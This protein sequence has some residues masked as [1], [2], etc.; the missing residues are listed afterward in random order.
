MAKGPEY[1][2]LGTFH[3]QVQCLTNE[4]VQLQDRNEKLYSKVEELQ[5]KL[6][7]LALSKADMSSRLICSEEEK[8]K[9]SK[10]FVDFQIDTNKKREQHEAENFELKNLILGL[11]NRILEIELHD[12]RTTGERDALQERLQTLEND[13][14][15]LANEYLALKSNYLVLGKEHEQELSKSE[16]LSRE[17]LNLVKSKQEHPHHVQTKSLESQTEAEEPSAEVERVQ[18]LIHRFS[19]RRAKPK[20]VVAAS[21]HED[22]KLE[23]SVS[24]NGAVISFPQIMEI[25]SAFHPSELLRN[26]G[27]ITEEMEKMR[28]MYSSQQQKL[29]ERMITMGKELQE[30][31]KAIRN[32]Q[33]KLA[34]E[35]A[36]LLSSHGQLQEVESENS[37]LQLQLKE[38]NEQYRS[39]LVQYITDLAEYTDSKSSAATK[40]P[41]Q[42][43]RFVDSM[44]KDIRASYKSR[45]EQL[46]RA[47]R[48]YKK[49]MQNLVKKHEGLLVAYRMQREQIRS[50][51]SP[52][53]DPGPPEHHFSITDAELLTNT[54]Q[55]LNRLREDKAS[56]EGQLYELQMKVKLSEKMIS[57]T[58]FHLLEGDGWAELRKQL[59]EFTHATQVELE[60]ERSQLLARAMVAEEQVAELQEY[61]DKHLVRY[62]QEIV[63]MHKLLGTDGS[64]ELSAGASAI[65]VLLMSQRNLNKEV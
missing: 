51:G 41:A 1:S 4:N 7:Q 39:H 10:D 38:L 29:E 35:S 58:S 15:E 26:Q 24:F 42:M 2:S 44:L 54:S 55:E 6:G 34:E 52:D 5:E 30:A 37:R 3:E 27:H 65:P 20:D 23:K 36:I 11:E 57:G 19:A 13:H 21:E 16:E 28:E 43:K 40:E 33:H 49:R 18:T 61:V 63:R 48:G 64:R 50:L 60:K 32:T 56:L 46:A 47:A 12:E 31:K 9:I 17:L 22:Q 45:E 8:L 53:L 14:K 59:R 25:D 62:K